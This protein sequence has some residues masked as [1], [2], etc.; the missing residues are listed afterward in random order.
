[1]TTGTDYNGKHMTWEAL[2]CRCWL[3]N[4]FFITIITSNGHCPRQS[5][6]DDYLY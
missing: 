4:Y 1:M 6:N 5:L 3:Q 2:Q